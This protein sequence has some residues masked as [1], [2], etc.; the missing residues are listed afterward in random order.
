MVDMA[1]RNI[2]QRKTRS[3]LTV[4]GVGLA[5][6]LYIY[7]SVIMN[8]YDKDLK[9]QLSSLA[10]KVVVSAKSESANGFPTAASVI[11][12][13][14]AEAVLRQEGVDETRSTPVLLQ[15]LVNNPAPNMPPLVQAVGLLPG[16]E[17]AYLG[18]SRVEGSARLTG[19][20]DAIL[21][22]N[23]AEHYKVK[24]GDQ[25]TVQ[26]HTFRVVGV[27][28]PS[29]EL[30]NNAVIMPLQTAQAA[31]VRPG[32]VSLVYVTASDPGQVDQVAGAIENAN[33]KLQA[34][35]PGGV[36]RSVEKAMTAQ[37]TFFAGVK[38]TVVTVSL[39]MIT[40]VMVMAVADRKK[41]IG[42]LK[43]L[44][45]S[46]WTIV[47][48]IAAEALVLSLSGGILAIPISWLRLSNEAGGMDFGLALQTLLVA[49]FVGVVSA[50]WPALAAVRVNPLESLSHE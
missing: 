6:M 12:I 35:G 26:D 47:G 4:I 39:I 9:R 24:A 40:I 37:R 17:T 50:V 49:V 7:L 23:A 43:A 28:E 48:T 2:W 45:A 5:V 41:E 25:L 21:G 19:P 20:D 8:W 14:D 33:T 10:G 34:A 32:V 3:V 11:P 36:A 15:P 16:R 29:Y 31:F 22:A 42:T 1:F 44:G 30:L 46:A 13:A 38:S 27:S 18:D